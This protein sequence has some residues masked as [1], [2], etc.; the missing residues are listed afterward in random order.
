MRTSRASSAPVILLTGADGQV[1]WELRRTLATLGEVV[2]CGRQQLN[3]EDEDDVRRVIG[4]VKPGVIVNAAAFTAVDRAEQEPALAMAVNGTAPGIIADEARRLGAAVVHYSTDFVFDGSA[5]RPYREED[6]A[7]PL[8]IYGRTKLAGER[9]LQEAGV[10]V[11]ILRTGWVYGCRGQNFLMTIQRLARERDALRIVDDQ[12]GT[13][14]WCRLL[15]E[16]TAQI[17][18]AG[19]GH[20]SEH[21]REHGGIHHLSCAGETSWCGFARRILELSS[22]GQAF[23]ARVE[24]IETCDY[25]TPAARPA[26]SVLDNAKVRTKFGIHLPDWERALALAL[27]DQAAAEDQECQ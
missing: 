17:L 24:A 12:I 27:A 9:A 26:Y 16:A 15:A 10:A 1:G 2:A 21:L 18:S 20:F 8:S 13:P 7:N 6:A 5:S 3:L 23:Q 11:L 4:S 14:T 22:P 25:P 19:G